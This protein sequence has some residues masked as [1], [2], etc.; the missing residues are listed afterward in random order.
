MGKTACAAGISNMI[1][2]F[3]VG[4]VE[5]VSFVLSFGT[6]AAAQPAT[7]ASKKAMAQGSKA[8]AKGTA[9]TV[10]TVAKA[11]N[12]AAIKSTFKQKVVEYVKKQIVGI[13]EETI[14]K[15]ICD[16]ISDV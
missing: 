10:K 1:A 14:I 5:F 8:T 2:Q 16:K 15:G 12:N 9:N 4:F 11:A 6:T 7:A 13:V 3:L